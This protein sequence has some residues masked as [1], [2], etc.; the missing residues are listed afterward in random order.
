VGITLAAPVAL[1]SINFSFRG[2]DLVV[3]VWVHCEQ[4]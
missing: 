2:E 4:A 1:S 3:L